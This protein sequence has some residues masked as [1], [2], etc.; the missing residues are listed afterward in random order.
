PVEHLLAIGVAGDDRLGEDDGDPA[1][2]ESAARAV[3]RPRPNIVEKPHADPAPEHDRGGPDPQDIHISPEMSGSCG[4]PS[5]WLALAPARLARDRS[6]DTNRTRREHR[7]RGRRTEKGRRITMKP[8]LSAASASP[9][10][11][12]ARRRR[13]LAVAALAALSLFAQSLGVGQ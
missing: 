10:P 12:G 7:G 8:F 3:G 1:R 11:G 6:R 5:W 4:F 2:R 9:R 13:R